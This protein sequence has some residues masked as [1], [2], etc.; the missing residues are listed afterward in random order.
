MRIGELARRS[1]V[2]V[3]TVHYYI[4]E[5]LLPEPPRRGKYGEFDDSYVQRLRLIQ[6]LKAERLSLPAIRARLAEMGLAPAQHVAR[7]PL[8]PSEQEEASPATVAPLAPRA[9]LFRSRFAEEAG[10]TP[11]QVSHLEALGLIGSSEGLLAAEDLPLARSVGRL[12]SRG[13]TL[14]DIAEIARQAREETALHSR[15]LEAAGATEPLTRA[16]QW[17][18]QAGAVATIRQ[19]L[20]RRWAIAR[21]ETAP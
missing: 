7:L 15:L 6:Q 20:L 14:E 16:L 10:L 21:P 19:M 9:G 4:E 13:A 2:T 11:E 17:Q 18:E 12:L 1:G 8:F 5:G 3:R